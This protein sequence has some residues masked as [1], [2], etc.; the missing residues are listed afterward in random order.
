MVDLA[1]YFLEFVQDESCGKCTPSNWDQA[2][3]RNLQRIT[4]GHG[5]EGD[6]ELL[7]EL[8]VQIKNTGTLRL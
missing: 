7:E 2:D 1:L 3:V 5:R 4:E 8:A 6:I